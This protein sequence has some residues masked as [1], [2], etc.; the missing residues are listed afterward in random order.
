M[1]YD[2]SQDGHPL[3]FAKILFR[4]QTKPLSNCKEEQQESQEKKELT[5]F[6]FILFFDKTKRFL[7]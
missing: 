4:I 7:S 1:H 2:C 3:T 6:K 5:R